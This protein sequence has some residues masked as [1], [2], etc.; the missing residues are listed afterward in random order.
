MDFVRRRHLSTVLLIKMVVIAG[1]SNPSTK[2]RG[3]EDSGGGSAQYSTT[4]QVEALLDKAL[5]LATDPDQQKNVLSQF[6]IDWGRKHK[7][8][9]IKVPARLFPNMI[10]PG[11][12][13]NLRAPEHSDKFKSPYLEALVKNKFLRKAKGD[14]MVTASGEHKDASVSSLTLHADICFSIGNLTRIPPSSLLREILGL[15]LHE[16]IHIGGGDEVEAKAWQ[17]EFS[18]YFGS[19]FGDLTADTLSSETF[20]SLS[21]AKVLLARADATA[22][23]DPKNPRIWGIMGRAAHILA[24]LPDLL[25]PLAIELKTNPR[26]PAL[27]KNYQNA[28]LALIHK[29]QIRFEFQPSPIRVWFH[30]IPINFLTPEQMKPVFDDLTKHLSQ[31]DENFLAFI[32]GPD[33]ARSVCILPSGDLDARIF[34]QNEQAQI[35]RMNFPTRVCAE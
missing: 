29:I 8:Q 10:D 12:G 34:G 35:A 6:W 27:I 13:Q 25:D 14:C 31:V 1:C 5:K 18:E 24:T 22:A 17:S 19:R 9:F 33:E 32:G 23:T 2:S 26:S 20:K 4:K 16:A 7:H 30:Q 15:L 11:L 21:S 3:T 28:V